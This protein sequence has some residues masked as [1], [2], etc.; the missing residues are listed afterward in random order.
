MIGSS[1]AGVT[2]ARRLAAQGRSVALMEVG[3]LELTP[4][5]QEI[6]EG[7]ITGLIIRSTWRGCCATSCGETPVLPG[8]A[9]DEVGGFHHMCT[10]RMSADPAEGV[11]DAD[12]VHGLANL[13]I[14]GSSVFAT[15]GIRSRPT[16][17]CSWRS[18]SATTSGASRPKAEVLPPG[19]RKRRGTRRSE[20][21]RICLTTS[22]ARSWTAAA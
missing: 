1:P 21:R 2:L 13:Y 20:S 11:V 14:G 18:G 15:T 12:K 4:E 3:G 7:E 5:S 9:E 6:Y 22:R 16:P 19:L 17:S 10:T 8:I